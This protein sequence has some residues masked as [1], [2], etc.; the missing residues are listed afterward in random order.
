MQDRRA[1][2]P[3]RRLA[4]ARSLGLLVVAAVGLVFAGLNRY[5]FPDGITRQAVERLSRGAYAVELE[6]ATLDLTGGLVAQQVR[7]YRKGVVGLPPFE[8]GSVRLGLEPFFWRWGR[9][10]WFR[11]VE[12]SDGVVRRVAGGA[13]ASGVPPEALLPFSSLAVRLQNVDVFDVLV[14]EGRADL[15]RDTNVF[16]V[17]RLA[18]TVGHGLRRGTVSGSLTIGADEVRAR[19]RT[20]VDPHVLVPGLRAFGIDQTRVFDWFSF[21]A[22]PPTGDW[23][24]E[25]RG[26]SAEVLIQGRL[27][28]SQ[29]ACRGTAIGFGSATVAYR[30]SPERHTIALNPLVL[31]VGGRTIG[32]T[33][34]VD[35]AGSTARFEALSVA[36]VPALA[37][38]VGF[39]EGSFL[40]AFRFAP[41]TRVYLHGLYDYG[42]G[43]GSDAE[44][45]VDSP[46][47]GYGAFNAEECSFKV[48]MAGETNLLQDVRGRLAGGSFTANAVFA[49]DAPGSTNTG[50]RLRIEVLHADLRSLAT[51]WGTN[52]L[53]RLDGRVYGNLDLAGLFGEGQG[54]TATGQGYVN[55]KRGTIF[56]IPLFGGFTESMTRVVPGLDFMTRQTDVRAP[57]EVRGG[58]IESKDIQVEGDVL[59]LAA[60]GSATL[61]GALD[62]DVQ[63][64]P[65]KDKTVVGAAMRAITYPLSKL[66][67]FHLAGTVGSPRWNLAPF[68]RG[69]ETRPAE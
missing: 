15:Q 58:R 39:R 23:T 10:A 63:V 3:R 67:E 14:E 40:D 18:A 7:V 11:E 62:F 25:R 1:G 41:E 32:G 26:G 21:P 60:R 2:G 22:A 53:P 6:R 29:F 66:F 65:M 35:L 48:R 27:Q 4:V 13:D 17:S 16:L 46:L 69:K 34:D 55:V 20:A 8:A 54:H 36:D 12:I 38:I 50:Y 24:F 5:G 28:A 51:V 30:W 33:L 64:R 31:A 9:Q 37:R 49:P 47:I 42:A 56:R 19:L 45:V 57:F 68:G 59:S 43:T 52:L 61:E 44:I